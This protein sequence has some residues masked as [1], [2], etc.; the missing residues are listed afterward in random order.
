MSKKQSVCAE[1][2]DGQRAE[3]LHCLNANCTRHNN[4][5]T[6]TL[7]CVVDVIGIGNAFDFLLSRTWENWMEGNGGREGADQWTEVQEEKEGES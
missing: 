5:G 3:P 7:R 4:R 1:T 2:E 6:V